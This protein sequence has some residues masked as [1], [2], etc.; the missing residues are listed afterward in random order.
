M[1]EA[2]PRSRKQPARSARLSQPQ[3]AAARCSYCAFPFIA[4]RQGPPVRAT[5]LSPHE[6]SARC[7]GGGRSS[8]S[9]QGFAF[10]ARGCTRSSPDLHLGDKTMAASPRPNIPRSLGFDC[11]CRITRRTK[12]PGAASVPRN[13]RHVRR[14]PQA[15]C[16]KRCVFLH[17][18]VRAGRGASGSASIRARKTDFESY[19]RRVG[20]PGWHPLILPSA[21]VRK[22]GL[23]PVTWLEGRW[24]S[25]LTA[26]TPPSALDRSRPVGASAEG[27][28]WAA[29]IKLQASG[30]S[31]ASGGGRTSLR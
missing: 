23:A 4:G 21:V 17:L 5:I 16:L 15:D 6:Q 12:L 29:R 13:Q 18:F 7:R 20:S 9:R 11:P 10:T 24:P 1:V 19:C 28:G 3:E 27:C 31:A 30:C 22:P 8:R 26:A 14:R 2:V 25:Q